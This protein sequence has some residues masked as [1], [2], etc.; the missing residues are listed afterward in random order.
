L[1]GRFLQ[2]SSRP[3]STWFLAVENL[4]KGIEISLP[5]DH[6]GIIDKD[7]HPRKRVRVKWWLP[8]EEWG[9]VKT[10]D[11]VARTGG[12]TLEKLAGLLIPPDILRTL[13]LNRGSLY[14]PGGP[15]FFGHFWFTGEPVPQTPYAACLDYSVAREG[16]LVCY[17]WDGEKTLDKAK[18][19]WV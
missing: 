6:P 14:R 18:F 19:L 12:H 16:K 8:E 11:Q 2:E 7:G 13:H 4:L 5:T 1:T 9:Q 15:I 17:R 10:Y 3:G